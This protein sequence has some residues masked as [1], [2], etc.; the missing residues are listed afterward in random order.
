MSLLRDIQAAAVDSKTD[1]ATLLRKCKILA[2]RLKSREFKEWVEH[3]LDGYP[4]IESLPPYRILKVMSKGHFSGPF[5]SGLRN[6]DIPTMNIPQEIREY[7]EYSHLTGSVASLESVTQGSGGRGVAQEAWPTDVV[8]LMAERFYHNMVCVQAWKVLP[9]PAM[10]GVLNAIRN[11]IINFALEIEAEAPDAGDAPASSNPVP[12]ELV[13]QIF[14]TYIMGTVHNVA[15]GGSNMDRSINVSGG[16]VG[17]ANQGDHAHVNV[18]QNVQNNPGV[19]ELVAQLRDLIT[20]EPGLVGP[21]KAEAIEQVDAIQEE[22]ER[23]QLRSGR[24]KAATAYLKGLV[25]DVQTAVAGATQI[26]GVLEAINKAV[27]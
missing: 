25:E 21:K 2:V 10:V 17:A 12:Q 26:Y 23:P 20:K 11:K 5:G 24:V 18:T 4:N 7:L 9:I 1:L 22:A 3:E 27:G 6:A 16:Q 19:V 13:R 14:N 15:S 8:A